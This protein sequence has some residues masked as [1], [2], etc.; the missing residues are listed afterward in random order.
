MTKVELIQIGDSVGFVLPEEI[1][2]RLKVGNGGTLLMTE[3]ASGVTLT[4]H[5]PELD[6][7][8]DAARRVMNKRRNA[9]RQ[10]PK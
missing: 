3:S 9:L 8:L 10:M 7:Q 1:L 2:A 6:G 5:D 4:P